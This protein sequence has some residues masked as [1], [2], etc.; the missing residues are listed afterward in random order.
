MTFPNIPN[1]TPLISITTEQTVPLLLASIAFEELA[2]AHI[3]NADAE[4][5]QFAVGTLDTETTLATPVT[6]SNLLDVNKS[7][8]R[9]LRD[10]IKKE[11]L[12]E[13]KFENIL[14]LIDT[15]P[16]ACTP[17]TGTFS[18]N[19]PLNV[20]TEATPLY[21]SPILVSG[22]QGLVSK[23]T[24]RVNGLTDTGSIAPTGI[25]HLRVLVV[26]PNGSAVLVVSEAGDGSTN[27]TP[28]TFTIE[29]GQP[30]IPSNNSIQPGTY[31]PTILAGTD[32]INF[33][34]SAPSGPYATSLSTFNGINPNGE[35]QVFASDE[36]GGNHINITQ[37]FTLT[38]T[39][40][41][42]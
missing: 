16:P 34:G 8:Q 20:S 5:L 14:D 2:L 28:I 9:T 37:G 18:N 33:P 31:G 11:M 19:T 12:L 38:I 1:V 4:K 26:A 22:L 6:V 30:L 39:T 32:S 42:P 41:C 3:M 40:A 21:P 36:F 13:F 17:S 23:V 15:F 24:V 7:V 35:W 10:V 25:G 29:D 27:L